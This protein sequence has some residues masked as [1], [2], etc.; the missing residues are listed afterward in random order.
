M[1]W[2]SLIHYFSI[3]DL[4]YQ[5]FDAYRLVEIFLGQDSTYDRIRDLADL[6]LA[7][8]VIGVSDLPNRMLPSVVCQLLTL[9]KMSAKPTW[10]YVARAGAALRSSY[11]NEMTSLL[12]PISS[13]VYD[14]VG[15]PNPTSTHSSATE[16]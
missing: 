6:D 3:G 13:S 11:S 14:L 7:V 9:R 8:M 12:E 2:R 16:S 5:Y 1:V 10:T 4:T 15:S